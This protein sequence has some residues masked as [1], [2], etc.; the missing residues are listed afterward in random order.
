M[1]EVGNVSFLSVPVFSRKKATPATLRLSPSALAVFR[2]CKLQYRFC[3]IDKLGEKYRKARP[4]YTMANHVHATL[5]D[6]L[7]IVPVHSRTPETAARLLKKNWR[8]YRAGFK[9][10]AD[11]RRWAQ[12]ALDE[13][14]RFAREQRL[15]VAPM[16]LEQPI[17][18]EITPGVILQGRVDR[19]D[20]EPDG[21]LHIIDYKTGP[22]PNK[23]DWTQ[24]EIHALI[25]CRSGQRTVTRV[26]YLY[27]LPGITHTSQLNQETLDSRAWEVL[28]V[29]EE[30]GREKDFPPSPGPPCSGCDFA[31]IC[32]AKD[33]R[34]V[35]M[36]ESDLRLWGDFS[37]LRHSTPSEVTSRLM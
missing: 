21:S 16:M 2:Q 28:R 25:L 35:M 13:V 20:R 18:A 36:G 22:L 6:L 32:P 33:R 24:L 23:I 27:L 29:A 12:R 26:S 1:G 4:Y 34:Y 11:E 17:E 10:E 7:S 37:D 3:Y 5:R 8:R 30:I 19:V 9:D 14:T 31:V 15:G